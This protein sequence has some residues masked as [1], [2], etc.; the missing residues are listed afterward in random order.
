MNAKHELK[1]FIDHYGLGETIN[2]L[3]DIFIENYKD[4]LKQTLIREFLDDMTCE[5]SIK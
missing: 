5:F 4:S 1:N 2:A 3:S